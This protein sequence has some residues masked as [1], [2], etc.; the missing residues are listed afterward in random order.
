MLIFS[1]DDLQL[2]CLPH[3]Y[4]NVQ[5][6][7]L[8]WHYR[9]SLTCNEGAPVVLI[10]MGFAERDPLGVLLEQ[11]CTAIARWTKDH[12]NLPGGNYNYIT[13]HNEDNMSQIGPTWSIIESHETSRNQHAIWWRLNGYIIYCIF[14]STGTTEC[15]STFCY[16]RRKTYENNLQYLNLALIWLAG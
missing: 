16:W 13:T 5:I 3:I 14:C 1:N 11:M 8:H 2:T 15:C 9:R 6:E 7:F 10:W 4:P 12:S